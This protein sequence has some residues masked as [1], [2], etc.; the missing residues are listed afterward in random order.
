MH[1]NETKRAKQGDSGAI[2]TTNPKAPSQEQTE[3]APVDQQACPSGLE[4]SDAHSFR[5]R[6]DHVLESFGADTY[7]R[8]HRGHPESGQSVGVSWP[9]R[10]IYRAK[11]QPHAGSDGSFGLFLC[12][13]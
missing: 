1:I 7:G 5:R 12:I 6:L 2:R 8:V 13:S 3:A 9:P 10:Q 4:A 11:N